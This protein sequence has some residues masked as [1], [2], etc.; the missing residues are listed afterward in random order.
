MA[1]AARD[2]YTGLVAQAY[3]ALV[4]MPPDPAPCAAF[5]RAGNGPALELGCGDGNP[6]LTLVADGLDVAGLDSSQDMLDRCRRAASDQGLQVTL[7]HGDMAAFDLGRRYRSIYIAGPT[8]NLLPDDAS[9]EAALGCIADHLE[10][11]GRVLMSFWIPPS[12]SSDELPRLVETESP[13]A[14]G[15]TLRCSTLRVVR[16]EVRRLQTST[17]R[18]ERLRD[19]ETVESVERPWVLH[20][21]DAD[22][23]R[24]LTAKA[25]LQVVS[26]ADFAGEPADATA[27]YFTMVAEA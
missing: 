20:W 23:V 26:L 5:V 1:E 14:D 19:G 24:E 7:H 18:Y 22:A 10:P 27:T 15:S 4:S 21:L 16:D 3:A 8:I 2:F 25:G 9:I 13:G 12:V 17:L 6:L 11:N